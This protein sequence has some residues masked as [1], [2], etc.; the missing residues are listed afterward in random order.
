MRQVITLCVA[1][2]LTAL[3]MHS[4]R[5]D[6]AAKGV[7]LS[8][9]DIYRTTHHIP[10]APSQKAY[11]FYFFTNECPVSNLYAPELNALVTRYS[12]RGVAFF[13]VDPSPN[14]TLQAVAA[15]ARDFELLPV[16]VKDFDGSLTRALAPATTAQVVVLDRFGRVAYSGRIDD[17][18]SVGLTKPTATTH[19]LKTAL[20][21]ILA[22]RKPPASVPASGCVIDM[23]PTTPQEAAHLSWKDVQPVFQSQCQPCHR[24]NGPAPFS[25]TNFHTAT[26][27]REMIRQALVE[28]RMPPWSADPA[29]GDFANSRVMTPADRKLLLSWASQTPGAEAAEEEKPEPTSPWFGAQPDLIWEG[30]AEQT[31]PATTEGN[32][33]VFFE[34][35]V[36]P[37]LTED[38]WIQGFEVLP[39]NRKVVHH[40]TVY[41]IPLDEVDH[42]QVDRAALGYLAA[43][44]PGMPPYRYP[45]SYAAKLLAGQKVYL[46]IHYTPNGSEQKDRTRIGVYLSKQKGVGQREVHDTSVRLLELDI[47]PE[48]RYH[49]V[50]AEERLPEARTLFSI[51]PHGHFRARSFELSAELPNGTK[52]VLISVPLYDFNWQMSYLFRVPVTF[53]AGTI[54]RCKAHFD[55]S[56]LN[57]SNPDPTK[58]V[59]WGINSFDE[60]MF[61][62]Y[63]YVV[64]DA[65][66]PTSSRGASSP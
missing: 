58:E 32:Q 14:D 38:T 57:P 44:V 15:H 7:S 17:R 16:I 59:H 19:E 29:V 39:S 22:N 66:T 1:L 37:H 52:T 46:Q 61:C 56:A 2:L 24:P 54:L 30:S 23:E 6:G 13:A 36:D 45:E 51:L 20:D 5:A 43:Y 11:V 28:Y 26:A 50:Y 33:G 48:A 8:F 10:S 49:K 60:M 42:T 41:A 63:D 31:I 53:P 4:A 12:S 18:Y 62:Y 27:M 40:V 64:A 47:P 3:P 21:A 65:S 35:V 25:L 34:E 9:R 55:N